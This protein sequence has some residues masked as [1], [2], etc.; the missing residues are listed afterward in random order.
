M[1]H[2]IVATLSL[3]LLAGAFGSCTDTNDTPAQATNEV[4]ARQRDVSPA[5]DEA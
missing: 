3:L 5:D 2:V 4:E 1:L